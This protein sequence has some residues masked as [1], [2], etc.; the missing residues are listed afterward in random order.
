MRKRSI[1]DVCEHF[2]DEPDAKR[3]LLDY[4]YSIPSDDSATGIGVPLVEESP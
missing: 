4:F 3:A 2:E 1:L